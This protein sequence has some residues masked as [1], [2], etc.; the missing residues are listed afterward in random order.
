MNF[1]KFFIALLACTASNLVYGQF[2]GKI[3][4][5]S[6]QEPI[7]GVSVKVAQSNQGTTT[8]TNG[9]FSLASTAKTLEVTVSSIGFQTQQL[10]LQAGTPATIALL[11]IS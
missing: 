3:F 6:T 9:V 5:S 8:N 7:V 10:T 2:S 11:T 4:D 1:L